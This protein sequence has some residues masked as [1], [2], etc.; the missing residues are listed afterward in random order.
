MNKN[1]NIL[2][3]DTKNKNPN[4][5]L[6]L[7][8]SRAFT[9]L[10]HV[11]S[12]V[13]YGNAIETALKTPPDI[14]LAF[15]GEGLNDYICQKLTSLSKHSVLWVTEDPYELEYNLDSS[16]YFDLIYTNDENCVNYY[17]SKVSHLPLAASKEFNYYEVVKNNQE[18]IYDVLFVG[19][20]WPNRVN[21]F[22]KLLKKIPNIKIKI[23]LSNNG[24]I[25][26]FNLNL[27]KVD[28]SWRVSNQELSNLANKS[29]ITITLNRSFSTSNN[30]NSSSP[31]PRLFEI[32]LA[33]SCQ[34]IEDSI[35]SSHKYLT[36]KE[37][38]L[39]FNDINEC[40]NHIK[41]FLSN[42]DKRYEIAKN[43]Q[44][45]I[46]SNHLYDHRVKKIINDFSKYSLSNNKKIKIDKKN[47][48]LFVTH[49]VFGIKPFGGVEVYQK[50]LIDSLKDRYN[51]FIYHVDRK[52]ISSSS[53]SLLNST[54]KCIDSF[55]FKSQINPFNLSCKER[56]E[57]FSKI[58]IKYNIGF[59]HYHHLIG[60][61]P[62][63]PLISNALGIKSI[64]SF[65]DYFSVCSNFNLINY[66]GKYCNFL[67]NQD[68][69]MCNKCLKKTWAVPKDIQ[70]KRINFFTFILSKI[71]FYHFNTIGV[72][73]NI[74]KIHP[75]IKN[76]SKEIILGIP[77]SG[78]VRNLVDF[79]ENTLNIAIIG[80]FDVNK[81][82]RLLIDIFKRFENK[83][84][85]FI[86]GS[87]GEYEKKYFKKNNLSNVI[88]KGPYFPGE[89]SKNLQNIHL[90]IH[91]S[92]WPETYCMTL[93][94]AWES[95][96]IPIVSDI[97][98]LGERVTHDHDGFKFPVNDNYK[99]MHLLLN[100]HE[101]KQNLSKIRKNILSKTLQKYSDHHSALKKIYNLNSNITTHQNI[102]YI[103]KSAIN[104]NH[105]NYYL[106][107]ADL[108]L[109]PIEKNFFLN[110]LK[111]NSIKLFKS[112]KND[113]FPVFVTK[114]YLKIK[115][116]IW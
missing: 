105:C 45:K 33:G 1:L 48:L 65:H 66:E 96:V 6:S 35:P 78:L 49:N 42:P 104:F 37:D 8:I 52:K 85:F 116:F 77:S 53:Y 92:I 91:N 28:Y 40:V 34:L 88:I 30:L 27:P 83:F 101:N 39:Y 114:L 74:L 23:G 84:N 72:K 90:S 15:D 5:Y 89:L 94:E 102:G 111:I 61:P 14:F 107:S 50:F 26:D 82:S 81:G 12:L 68:F 67:E 76:N 71:D 55:D 43:S 100:I 51:I 73:K 17:K 106:H 3:L 18:L 41:F 44:N 69:D 57:I 70:N 99:L 103:N 115:S 10:K 24:D 108:N 63:L 64:F 75:G 7:S 29:R 25:P 86:I 11:V 79:K 36:N 13:N 2:I 46:L 60:H 22:E 9:E 110:Q 4:H 16:K 32:G 109:K 31:G 97:G 95:G 80:N 56:E 20:A 113:S 98:A 38:C 93:T 54:L 21:F 59:V 112:L 62:S 19:T 58:L 87:L 47:N